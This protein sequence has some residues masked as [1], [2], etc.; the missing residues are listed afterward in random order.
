VSVALALTDASFE[1]RIPDEFTESRGRYS[2]E[3][4]RSLQTEQVFHLCQPISP[5]G[6][7]GVR[8]IW[9]PEVSIETPPSASEAAV[10]PTA[11]KL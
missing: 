7:D 10:S 1:I 4:S 3:T 5:R 2:L 11:D 8:L 9:A 6:V